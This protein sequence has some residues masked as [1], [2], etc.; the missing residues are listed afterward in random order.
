MAVAAP[1]TLPE[2]LTGSP[3]QLLEASNILC[4][5]DEVMARLLDL[6]TDC[7]SVCVKGVV[8]SILSKVSLIRS[9]QEST[10]PTLLHREAGIQCLYILASENESDITRSE[11]AVLLGHSLV[12]RPSILSVLLNVLSLPVSSSPALVD[13]SCVWLASILAQEIPSLV[14]DTQL[15]ALLTSRMSASDPEKTR[16]A[17]SALTSLVS[18]SRSV[19]RL[20]DM[21]TGSAVMSLLSHESV[22]EAG[23]KLIGSLVATGSCDQVQRLLDLQLYPGLHFLMSRSRH[24]RTI[25]W[26]LA[27]CAAGTETQIEQMRSSGLLTL[28]CRV[29]SGEVDGGDFRS[30][31]EA[32]FCVS[33]V[34]SCGS[35]DQLKFLCEQQQVIEPL[36]RCLEFDDVRLLR[37][38]LS[39]CDNLLT[40]G[41]WM[42]RRFGHKF[43]R[44][45]VRLDQV[46]G[47]DRLQLLAHTSCDETVRGQARSLCQRFFPESRF[48]VMPSVANFWFH[49]RPIASDGHRVPKRRIQDV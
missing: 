11:V 41:A 44:Y 46:G 14:L 2:Q 47:S 22:C 18:G 34:T 10:S 26:I 3:S 38:V 45:A 7:P 9:G 16:D 48:P 1:L 37:T 27:N 43:N 23:L 28:V 6:L 49:C 35:L 30:R 36:I 12:H 21:G 39:A 42:A 25:C 20:L 19:Q 31:R 5:G 17:C 4:R 13:R 40:C 15:P 24:V 32:A 29:L 8:V 33:H